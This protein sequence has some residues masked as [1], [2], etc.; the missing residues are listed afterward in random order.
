VFC[1]HCGLGQPK[2]HRFCARCG[3]R[4]P[5][6]LL[7]DRSPKVSRWFWSFPASPGDP[8]NAALRVTRYLQEY[9]IET[10]DGSVRVPNHHV[11]FSVWVDDRVTCALSISDQEAAEL[12]AFLEAH[13]PNGDEEAAQPNSV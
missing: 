7:S 9:E 10:A 13:V 5:A 8:E 1:P 3:T 11:R 2:E 6:E 4:L 12:A